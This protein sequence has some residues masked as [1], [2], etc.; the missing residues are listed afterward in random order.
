MKIRCKSIPGRFR[1]AGIEFTGSP[2][3]YD[4]NEKTLGILQG[5]PM[6]VVEVVPEEKTDPETGKGKTPPGEG[7]PGKK[8]KEKKEQ[9]K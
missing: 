7:S 5:E 4:V 2:A 3:E 1:R 6:L 8:E 9:G